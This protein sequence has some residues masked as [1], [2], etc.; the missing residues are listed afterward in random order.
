MNLRCESSATDECFQHQASDV[1][2]S[3]RRCRPRIGSKSLVLVIYVRFGWLECAPPSTNG[4]PV[5]I[6]DR[7]LRPY[8]DW[9]KATESYVALDCELG[10][11]K[12]RSYAI[13]LWLGN[14]S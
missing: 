11:E 6:G 14:S 4:L 9:H 1:L 2:G 3:R 12:G 5:V 13:R 10:E 8:L 7:L